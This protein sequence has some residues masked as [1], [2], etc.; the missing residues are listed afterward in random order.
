MTVRLGWWQGDL[1]EAEKVMRGGIES[2]PNDTHLLEIF[3]DFLLTSRCSPLLL[4][5]CTCCALCFL[6]IQTSRFAV[7]TLLGSG[8]PCS[9]FWYGS[10][11][12]L[13]GCTCEED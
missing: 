3:A 5:R 8:V 12:K 10:R 4:I 13:K 2:N 6:L 11:R 9:S 7:F 1:D